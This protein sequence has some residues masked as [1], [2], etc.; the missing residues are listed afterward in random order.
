MKKI[1][2]SL[3]GHSGCGKSTLAK[4]IAEHL[5]F[6]YID[7]GA[8]YR[9]MTLY[10]RE[11]KLINSKN[12]LKSDFS[13]YLNDIKID[14]SKVDIDGKTWVRLNDEIVESEIRS[15]S[16][17]NLVSVV[18]QSPV[19]RNK[20][21][22]LQQS[23]GLKE[24]VVMDGRDIGTVVFPNAQLKFWLTASADKRANRRFLEYQLNGDDIAFEKV[25]ENIINRDKLDENRNISPL[26]KPYDSIEIDN[27]D[28]TIDETFQ[29]AL[30]H[31]NKFL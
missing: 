17:S 12:E 11:N 3:D 28:L 30:L 1:I 13:N 7:S 31:I 14:F 16:I 5:K 24:N 18:S 6:T 15:I 26:I 20:L 8:M 22:S 19:I 9:A 4:L 2:I 27:S 23:Y 25:R 29:T 21:I 10:L